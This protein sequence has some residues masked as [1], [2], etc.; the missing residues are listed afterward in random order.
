MAMR[1]PLPRMNRRGRYV[2]IL[3]V[4]LIALLTATG[5]MVGIWT[6]YLWYDEVKF[7]EVFSTT[8]RSRALLFVVFGGLMALWVGL[9]LWLAYRFRPSAAMLTSP[10]QQVLDRYRRALSPRLKLWT[11]LVAGVVG[12]FTG[13][14][15]QD[16]WQSWLLFTNSQTVGGEPDPQFKLDIGFYLF[17]YPF[18]TYILSVAFTATIIALIGALGAHYLYGAIRLSGR[19]ERISTAARVHL[20][21]LIA[22]FVLLKA[23]AYWFDRFGLVITEN[24]V[25]GLTGGGYAEMNA[26]LFAKEILIFVA[27][28]GAV[29]VVI[30][31]NGFG[32]TML[33]P[34]CAIGLVV[35]SAIAI[36]GIYPAAV[37]SIT[38]QPNV[39]GKEGKYVQWSIDATRAAYGMTDV[40][41]IETTLT[42]NGDAKTIDADEFTVPNIRLLDPSIVSDTFSQKQ[43][44]RGFHGF[45]D[46][47][48]VD[49]YMVDGKLQ[50]FVVGVRE[51][52]PEKY[53]ATQ[54]DW[55]VRHTQYTHGYGFVAAPANEICGDGEPYFVSGF[56]NVPAEGQ[57]TTSCRSATDLIPTDRPQIYYGELMT[58]YAVVGQPEGSA[59]REYDHPAGSEDVLT[60]YEGSGGVSMSSMWNRMLY[61]WEF[62]E[63]KFLLSDAFNDESKLLYN[64]NPR[65]RVEKVA[66]F[67]TVDGD[68]YPAVVDGKIVWILDGYTTASTYPYSDKVNLSDASTDTLTGSG[69]TQQ[70]GRDVNYIRN[71]V[72]ATVDAYDGTVN[73]YAYDE[74]DPVLKAWNAA[75]GGIVKP[76]A[77]IPASLAAHFRYP[78][79]LFKIQRDLLQR[80]HVKDSQTFIQGSDAW[81]TPVDPAKP[82]EGKQPPYYVVANYPGQTGAQF[83]LTSTMTPATRANVTSAL[84]SAYYDETGAP[85]LSL[86]QVGDNVSS[87]LQ[88]HQNLTSLDTV[89][90]DLRLFETEK[91]NVEYGNMLALPVGNGVLYV[92]PLY[93]RRQGTGAGT[94]LPQMRKVLVSY[95]PYNAYANTLPEALKSIVEQYT[96]QTP[97]TTDPGTEEPPPPTEPGATDPAVTAAVAK[98]NQAIEDLKAAQQSG[99]FEAYGKALAALDAAIKEY[100]AAVAAATKGG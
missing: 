54:S 70:A 44:A 16:Q 43:Q 18:W 34:A 33:W 76:K 69:T 55:T 99:D 91:T 48:D 49:R 9:N 53:S 10:D 86:Y 57:D 37:K 5:W 51:L 64:R 3:L 27:I 11:G 92:E 30:F 39:P 65:D 90:Q 8:L 42:A 15:A 82:G 71:S 12:L 46:K 66:P 81:E 32:K 75:F 62:R 31:S 88:T 4:G 45:S 63:T 89:V 72:K 19:G 79:D 78:E 25:T 2:L 80:F 47:L 93:L 94:T 6:D 56:L 17:E 22:L 26:L 13:L 28:I 58:D 14:A 77:E 95:G 1:N 59:P 83:Q 38:V 50:D 97:P 73:L 100:D 7:T 98:M 84:L 23:V 67:L 96:G 20:S 87:S 61:A 24:S 21:S 40:N 35:V 41:P 36:G 74:A 85:K 60:T 68:P 29:A 52:N